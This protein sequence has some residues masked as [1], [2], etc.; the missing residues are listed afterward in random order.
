[1]WEPWGSIQTKATAEN[2]RI[3]RQR[4]ILQSGAA[5]NDNIS[6]GRNGAFHR[7][8][9]EIVNHVPKVLDSCLRGPR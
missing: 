9:W 8:V 2:K 7:L 5:Q 6:L 3:W 1:M 4:H